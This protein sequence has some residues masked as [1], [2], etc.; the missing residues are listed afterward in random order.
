M[1]KYNLLIDKSVKNI[2]KIAI[3]YMLSDK[4]VDNFMLKLIF[5]KILENEKGSIDNRGIIGNWC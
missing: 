3:G 5:L 1:H 4:R 2:D